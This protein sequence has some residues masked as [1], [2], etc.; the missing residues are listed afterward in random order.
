MICF[1]TEGRDELK[2]TPICRN[3]PD[4]PAFH[5]NPHQPYQVSAEN[6]VKLQPGRSDRELFNTTSVL[7]S[8]KNLFGSF[9]QERLRETQRAELGEYVDYILDSNAPIPEKETVPS[10]HTIQYKTDCCSNRTHQDTFEK[11]ACFVIS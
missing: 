10:S 8:A 7:T 1:R 2:L 5:G 9:H 3:V 4:D 11:D 6:L